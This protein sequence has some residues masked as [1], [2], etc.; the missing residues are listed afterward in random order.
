MVAGTGP[1]SILEGISNLHFRLHVWK[2]K[3]SKEALTGLL[4]GPHLVGRARLGGTKAESA[5]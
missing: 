4:T 3:L 2:P 1:H 5:I